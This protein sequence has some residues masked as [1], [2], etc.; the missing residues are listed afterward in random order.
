M[1][2]D[3]KAARCEACGKPYEKRRPWARFCST[4]CRRVAFWRRRIAAERRA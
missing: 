4:A 1:K 3:T 2:E